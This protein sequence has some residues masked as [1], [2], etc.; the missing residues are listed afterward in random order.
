MG[1]QLDE[2]FSQSNLSRQTETFHVSILGHCF[3]PKEEAGLVWGPARK[4]TRLGSGPSQTQS[5]PDKGKLALGPIRVNGGGIKER[6]SSGGRD[7]RA[8]LCSRTTPWAWR[9]GEFSFSAVC[10][11]A[12][13]S[14]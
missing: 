9:D 10:W 13:V 14:R 8:V 5:V 11:N 7:T 4:I 2:Q 6:E 12:K 1:N 3:L